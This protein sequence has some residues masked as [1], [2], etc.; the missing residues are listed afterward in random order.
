[1]SNNTLKYNT[2]NSS[3]KLSNPI[4]MT[5][6]LFYKTMMATVGKMDT[7]SM[8]PE[9]DEELNDDF[10]HRSA[11]YV[12]KLVLQVV[13]AFLIAYPATRKFGDRFIVNLLSSIISGML[14]YGLVDRTNRKDK[15]GREIPE[16]QDNSSMASKATKAIL[17]GG[18]LGAVYSF[19]MHTVPAIYSSTGLPGSR[20][21][22]LV[23]KA[24]TLSGMI[25]AILASSYGMSQIKFGIK[26][27][28][29]PYNELKN[30]PKVRSI[31]QSIGM[32]NMSFEDLISN[33]SEF[34]KFIS[35][36]KDASSIIPEVQQFLDLLNNSQGGFMGQIMDFASSVS[37][38][39]SNQSLAGR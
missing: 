15:N 7:K 1:M 34:K 25:I 33:G 24:I 5:H 10:K 28:T 36:M 14:A 13:M 3:F 22:G 26:K 32:E 6:K 4:N 2:N 18:F 21:I 12:S 31:L 35:A 9:A 38:A 19:C 39:S 11:V 29:Q 20:I 8:L 23:S 16:P 30:N 37:N 17:A 27:L